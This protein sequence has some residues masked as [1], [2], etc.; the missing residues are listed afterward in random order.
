MDR[1][2]CSFCSKFKVEDDYNDWFLAEKRTEGGVW[3]FGISTLFEY[4]LEMKI[5]LDFEPA[6]FLGK[7]FYALADNGIVNCPHSFDK[8]LMTPNSQ[9]CDPRSLCKAHE[10]FPW[11]CSK[12]HHS[13]E[14]AQNMLRE[15]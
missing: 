4:K 10:L 6:R 7:E 11:Q 1:G 5:I 12:P 9:H 2:T 3:H 14:L 13:T 15:P 8:M